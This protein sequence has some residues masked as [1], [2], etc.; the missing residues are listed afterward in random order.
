MREAAIALIRRYYDAF[1]AGD[2]AG[3]IA[4]LNQDVRH[5]VNEGQARIGTAKFRDFLAHMDRCYAERLSDLA[6]MADA[7]GARAAAEFVVHGTYLATDEGL[8]PARG[9]TYTLPA[10][11][12]FTIHEGRIAR[13][14]TYYNLREWVRQVSAA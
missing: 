12:F 14:T 11:A 10:G 1:N 5:D 13:I 4:C 9:Q 2:R 6:V 7:A 3:M 8:P